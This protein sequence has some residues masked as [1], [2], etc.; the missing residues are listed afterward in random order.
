M[1]RDEFKR[2]KEEAVLCL[3]PEKILN[4]FQSY[5]FKHH[6]IPYDRVV[7][8]S[9][10]AIQRIR[11]AVL[12]S[13]SESEERCHEISGETD[14]ECIWVVRGMA[15]EDQVETLVHEAMHDSVF[16]RRLT[17]R[18]SCKSLSCDIEHGA[19]QII[20]Y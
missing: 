5:L 7:F 19:M 16:I 13:H 20:G 2:A 17:R 12:L 10:N 1:S 4:A 6:K 18:G 14:G 15:Y 3:S 8:N 9:M 11:D